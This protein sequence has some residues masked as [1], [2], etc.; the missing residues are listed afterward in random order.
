MCSETLRHLSPAMLQVAPLNRIAL[1][2]WAENG[3]YQNI[4]PV[5]K[6]LLIDPGH[7]PTKCL[8]FSH[9]RRSAFLQF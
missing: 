2:D 6:N 4:R 5:F 9:I 3:Y 7:V 1:D 8:G